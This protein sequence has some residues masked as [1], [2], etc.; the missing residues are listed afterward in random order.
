MPPDQRGR[1]GQLESLRLSE[2]VAADAISSRGCHTVSDE[3]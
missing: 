1:P 2:M 3:F